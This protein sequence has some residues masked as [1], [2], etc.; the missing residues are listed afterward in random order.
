[1][2]ANC[3][4]GLTYCPK[5]TFFICTTPSKGAFKRD[6]DCRIPILKSGSPF[7]KTLPSLNLSLI[8]ITSPPMRALKT[9]FFPGLTRPFERT[10]ICG[11]ENSASIT[12]TSF[13]LW[14]LGFF[15]AVGLLFNRV[16]VIPAPMPSNRI[17]SQNFRLNIFFHIIN[18][19]KLL[20][21]YWAKVAKI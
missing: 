19:V 9:T 13:P 11:L 10:S 20:K 2:V 4:P 5:S 14:K 16:M 1:M 12:S 17:G 15:L 21:K 6:W 3:V 8:Q 7:L 18:S